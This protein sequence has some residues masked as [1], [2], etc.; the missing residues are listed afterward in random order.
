MKSIIPTILVGGTGS[1]LWPMS[2]TAYPKQFLALFSQYS[3][4]QETLL[5]AQ[6]IAPQQAPII[7]GHEDYRF[8]IAEQLRQL[9]ITAQTIILEPIAKNTAPAIALAAHYAQHYFP[10]AYLMIFPADHIIQDEKN[11]VETLQHAQ[12]AMHTEQLLTFGI[13][14]THAETAYG[15][16]E[17]D[18]TERQHTIFPVSSFTEKP[19]SKTAAQ[20]LSNGNYYWNSGMFL[21]TAH[22]Y[23]HEIK[24]HSPAMF[25]HTQLAMQEASID[26]DFLRPQLSAIDACP[27]ESIDYAIMEKTTQAVV[28]PLTTQWSDIG[29][30]HALMEQLPHADQQQNVL[31]G[32][33][34]TH[35]VSNS[36]IRSN[37]RLVAAIGVNNLIIV[38]TDDALLVMD[39]NASQE[40]KIIVNQ[41]KHD[42]RSEADIHQT[43]YRPWGSYQNLIAN[44]QF[45][46]KK[47]TVNPQQ[48]LSLQMHHHRS[49]HWVV[50]NGTATVTKGEKVF[51]LKQNESTFIPVT[52]KHRLENNTAQPLEIIE[53][54]TG[55]KLSEDDIVRFADRYG[56]IA[57]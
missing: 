37:H 42:K 22:T 39:K 49:E 27:A 15:Y 44:T 1:R 56:R 29:S 54:Q 47:I 10:D 25:Q 38:D 34:L 19:D 50:V 55:D 21:F 16:I 4:F 12:Q 43:V 33:V 57:T 51:E 13:T 53:I 3:L 17:A 26:H 14:P 32:D 6:A 2:R 40:V 9:N 28:I 20:Y 36:Y 11:L 24:Q 41:L 31:Q 7:V 8:I 18:T 35:N 52:V 23:L 30:W 45:L 48:Q 46:V 5:R